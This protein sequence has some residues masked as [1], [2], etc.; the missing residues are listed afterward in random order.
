MA[1]KVSKGTRRRLNKKEQRLATFGTISYE[2]AA[3]PRTRGRRPR[4]ISWRRNKPVFRGPVSIR[5]S[6][7]RR[8]APFS[9]APRREDG[10]GRARSNCMRFGSEK[11]SSRLMARSVTAAACTPC[12]IRSMKTANSRDAV[13][14][15]C[16]CAVSGGCL[17]ARHCRVRSRHRRSPL[18]GK[19]LRRDCP[20]FRLHHSDDPARLRR[21]TARG[22]ASRA[23]RRIKRSPRIWGL[24]QKSR[25][26]AARAG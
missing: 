19:H 14:A 12:S 18:Q 17:L 1:A 20:A 23:K 26:L 24:I 6:R 5:N 3:D 15:I 10:E 16:C 21:W 11:K 25:G 7:D 9:T 4:C 22:P 8:C 13:P 2:R